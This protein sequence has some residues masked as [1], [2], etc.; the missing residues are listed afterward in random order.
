[1]ERIAQKSL[2]YGLLIDAG[3][4]GSRLYVYQWPEHSGRANDLL[5]ITAAVGEDGN[6]LIMKTEPGLSSFAD[7]I[8]GAYESLRPLLDFAAHVCLGSTTIFKGNL[9]R[10]RS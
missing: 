5:D 1:V 8:D 3:S 10:K 6:P 2:Q 7:S 4:S 9:V